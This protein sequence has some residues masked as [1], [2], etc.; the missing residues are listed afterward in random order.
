MFK[1]LVDNG[2]DFLFKAISELDKQP[3]YSV[4]HFYTAVELLVKSR[5]MHEHWSLV[6]TKRQEPDWDK[7]IS[8]DFQSVSLDEAAIR[9]DKIVRSGLSGAELSAFREVA[10]HRNKM[11]HFFHEMHSTEENDRLKQSIIKQQLK[12]WYFLQQLLS[13]Q[14]SDVF[15]AWSDKISEIDS[16]L[17]KLHEFLQVV[18]DSL[19][20]KIEDMK[21]EGIIFEQCPSCGFNSQQHEDDLKQIY[22]ASCMVCGLSEKCLKIEC[23]D[24]QSIITFRNE[25]VGTCQSCGKHL[26]PDVVAGELIDSAAAHIA[27]M[28]GDDSWDA[29]NCSGCDGYHTV[30][31]TENNDWICAGCFEVFESLGSCGW[32]NELNTGD[33]ED[34]YVTGCN[35]CEGYAGWHKDD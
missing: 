26:E 20:P 3:K 23:P 11:V 7:F 32:C 34:S 6:V 27:V 8:G 2:F 1:N 10:K 15:S 12:A 33:M 31:R 19:R 21:N 25:G 18:F 28:D 17:K 35:F 22:E 24:C 4:I 14:W 13:V 29:G 5:L 9:L 16:S 30:V